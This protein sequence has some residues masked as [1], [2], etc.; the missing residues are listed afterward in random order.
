MNSQLIRRVGALALVLTI[1]TAATAEVRHPLEVLDRPLTLPGGQGTAE[2][3]LIIQHRNF[4]DNYE[5]AKGMVLQG[6]YGL[7]DSIDAR[8]FYG[9]CLEDNFDGEGS[10]D[11]CKIGKGVLGAELGFSLLDNE[12]TDFAL[13]PSFNINVDMPDNYRSALGVRFRHKLSKHGALYADGPVLVTEAFGET[14]TM[15]AY[16]FGL[17]IGFGAQLTPKFFAG[18]QTVLFSVTKIEGLDAEESVIFKNG[19]PILLTANY[20]VSPSFEIALQ[21]DEP[22]SIGSLTS[23]GFRGYF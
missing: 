2:A 9:F 11:S 13:A 1:G 3:R 5:D 23:I 19:F 20:A 15:M 17:P 16:Q 4:D 6:G 14:T 18:V 10:S 22:S 21:L 7:T 8:L 12:T